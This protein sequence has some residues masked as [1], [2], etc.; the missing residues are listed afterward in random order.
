LRAYARGQHGQIP[1]LQK[2][3]NMY[4]KETPRVISTLPLPKLPNQ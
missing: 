3:Q 2:L 1:K 4:D